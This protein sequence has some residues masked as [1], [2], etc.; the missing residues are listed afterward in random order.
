VT[1]SL[2][3]ETEAVLTDHAARLL[4]PDPAG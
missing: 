3:R 4:T 1:L 2:A